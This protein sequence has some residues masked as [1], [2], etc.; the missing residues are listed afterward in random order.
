MHKPLLKQILNKM[1]TVPV[2]QHFIRQIPYSAVHCTITHNRSGISGAVHIK[3]QHI[4]I[5]HL[6][7]NKANIV[8]GPITVN[9]RTQ[10]LCVYMWSRKWSRKCRD[11]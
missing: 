11:T 1:I 10:S 4:K 3:F 9:R 2:H 7:S 8:I 6:D 5:I